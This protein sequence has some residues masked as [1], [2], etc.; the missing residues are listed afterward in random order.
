MNKREF[1]IHDLLSKIYQDQFVTKK[2]LDIY[3]T[4]FLC[5]YQIVYTPYI[6]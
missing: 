5:V 1:I 2:L 3:Y 6:M 4:Y